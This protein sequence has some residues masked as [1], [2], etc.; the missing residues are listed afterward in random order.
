MLNQLSTGL[1]RGGC[2]AANSLAGD[3]WGR[4]LPAG[5]RPH[6]VQRICMRRI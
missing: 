1:I 5:K 3:V 6:A 2:P 4:G